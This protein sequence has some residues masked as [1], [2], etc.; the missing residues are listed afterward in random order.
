MDKR[1]LM[2]KPRLLDPDVPQLDP[3]IERDAYYY[4][5]QNDEETLLAVIEAVDK[6]FKPEQIGRYYLKKAGWHRQEYSIR[7]KNAAEHYIAL[8][9]S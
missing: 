9:E 4:L 5:E 2:P 3:V 8:S 6:G 7:C 1:P